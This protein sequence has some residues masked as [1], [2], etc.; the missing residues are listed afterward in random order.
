[1]GYDEQFNPEPRSMQAQIAGLGLDGERDVQE[2]EEWIAA[3]QY[4]YKFMVRQAHRLHDKGGRVSARY[5]VHM[6][7][8]ELHV[9]V[10][11]GLSPAF[12]RIMERDYPELRG[13]FSTHKSKSDGYV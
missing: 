3:N 11:N 6:V 8:N 4:A 5:L 7:R 12:A 13:A 1:M 2:A 10:K 9:S